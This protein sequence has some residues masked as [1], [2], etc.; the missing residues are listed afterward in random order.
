MLDES[1]TEKLTMRGLA[2]RLGVAP[3][4]VYWHVG[5]KRALLQAAVDEVIAGLAGRVPTRGEWQV[6]LHGFLENAH[7]RLVAHPAVVEL[8]GVVHPNTI[9]PVATELVAFMSQVGFD[10]DDAATFARLTLLHA[11][12]SARMVVAAADYLERD[13]SRPDGPLRR[14]RPELLD[15]DL[16]DAV[17]RMTTFDAQRERAVLATMFVDGL[18]AQRRRRRR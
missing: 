1:G 4:A 14:V 13:P 9:G 15:P 12:N 18:A 17:V 16:P 5:S 8:L 3:P 7:A 10:E 6:R 11:I 2:D